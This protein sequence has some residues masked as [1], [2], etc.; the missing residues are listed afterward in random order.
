VLFLPKGK[1]YVG[2]MQALPFVLNIGYDNNYRYSN[3]NQ[4]ANPH[5]F[6]NLLGSWEHADYSI[7]GT[8]MIR[9]LMGGREEYVFEKVEL[10]ILQ[11]SAYPNPC[12]DQLTVQG[13]DAELISDLAIVDGAGRLMPVTWDNGKINVS[14]LS[15]GRYT[16]VLR[17]VQGQKAYW[18]FV[19]LGS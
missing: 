7:K 17:T 13:I 18:H 6:Y 2:W 3:D 4:V 14:H 11:I 8:P 19:K 15:N 12:I 16:L 5:L 9:M 1:Y 10:P